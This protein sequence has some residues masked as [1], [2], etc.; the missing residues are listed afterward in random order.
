MSFQL[1][2]FISFADW[3]S[4]SFE[5]YLCFETS[6]LHLEAFL[7]GSVIVVQL[8][9]QKA[10]ISKLFHI[11]LELLLQFLLDP[12]VFIHK[13]W[14]A[15]QNIASENIS[16]GVCANAYMRLTHRTLC[17]VCKRFWFLSKSCF[18]FSILASRLASSD[19]TLLSR[20]LVIRMVS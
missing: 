11:R 8:L 9:F 7:L 14:T 1:S 16:N 3:V 13:C 5:K 12:L 4:D 10:Q 15:H 17:R 6:D 20:S 18:F 2:M 19:D